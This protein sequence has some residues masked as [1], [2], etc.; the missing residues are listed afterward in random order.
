VLTDPSPDRRWMV[1][2]VSE[3]MPSVNTF[4]RPHHYFAGLQV[5]PKA[6]RARALTNRGVAGLELV[7]LADGAVRRLETPAGATVS[8]P[9]WSPG[10]KEIAFIA[11]FDAASHVYVADVATGRSRQVTRT[12]LLATLA[13]SVDWTADGRSA[14]RP[15]LP[16]PAMV[17]RHCTGPAGFSG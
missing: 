7:S 12:P 3:G 10:G 6:N 17:A 13:T 4:G 8:N 5:D 9:A 11:N 15:H 14:C 16:R 2:E 1:R